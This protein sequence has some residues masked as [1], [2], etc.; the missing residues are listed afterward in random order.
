MGQFGDNKNVRHIYLN[1]Y[2]LTES[3]NRR[4]LKPPAHMGHWEEW[5]NNGQKVLIFTVSINKYKF[6]C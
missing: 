1:K 3:D 6:V 5:S 2:S 4:T